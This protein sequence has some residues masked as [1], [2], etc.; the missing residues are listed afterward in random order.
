MGWRGMMIGAVTLFL[1]GD[2]TKDPVQRDLERLQ[3]T[4]VMIGGEEK[5]DVLTPREAKDEEESIVV[6]GDTFTCFR[7]GKKRETW[8]IRLDP[9]RKPAAVDLIYPDGQATEDGKTNHAIYSLEGDQ[10]ILCV[11]RK[12]NPN[13]PEERPI[14]LT[15]KKGENGDLRGMVLGIYQRQKK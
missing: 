7:H 4:W 10:F 2:P 11:S 3:G 1:A 14:K 5:G 8:T 13:S 6:K 9:K 15:T 12:F